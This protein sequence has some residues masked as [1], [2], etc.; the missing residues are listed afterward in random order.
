MIVQ[1]AGQCT[2]QGDQTVDENG[3][4]A[5]QGY[6]SDQYGHFQ[7]LVSVFQDKYV[8]IGGFHPC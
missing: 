7:I 1:Y 5:P 3:R 6:C 4:C 2:V 8:L